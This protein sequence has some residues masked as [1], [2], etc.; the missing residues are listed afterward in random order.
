MSKVHGHANRR[1]K[2]CA[3]ESYYTLKPPVKDREY[4]LGLVANGPEPSYQ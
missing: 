3:A 4:V 1:C 2:G